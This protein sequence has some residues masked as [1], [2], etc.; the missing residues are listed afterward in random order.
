M[1]REGEHHGL[2]VIA[3]LRSA[4]ILIMASIAL[5]GCSTVKDTFALRKSSETRPM[6]AGRFEVT[7][8]GNNYVE[9]RQDV[10]NRWEQR[11]S[12][13]CGGAYK[14]VSRNYDQTQTPLVLVNGVIECEHVASPPPAQVT[15]P[16]AAPAASPTAQGSGRQ[17]EMNL[18]QAQARLL[19]LGYQ[20]GPADGRMGPRTLEALQ[21]FQRDRKLAVTGHLDPQTVNELSR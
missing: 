4:A 9:N 16:A 1:S 11:A 2:D 15:A 6:G 13:A 8:S 12:A 20:P 17:Q 21:K 5:E 10:Y 19:A 3:S 14:V 18:A 7:E